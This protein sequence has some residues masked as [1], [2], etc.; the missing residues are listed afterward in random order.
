MVQLFESRR[1]LSN[2]DAARTGHFLTDVLVIGSGVAGARAAL[3]AAEHADVILVAKR[4]LLES[5]TRYACRG[6]G[7]G[8]PCSCC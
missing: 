5:A 6:T 7:C 3:A 4:G 2:F 1:Y 8:S